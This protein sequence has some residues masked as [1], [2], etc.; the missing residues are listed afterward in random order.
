[1]KKQ[2]LKELLSTALMFIGLCITNFS[3]IQITGLLIFYLGGIFLYDSI[4]N[5]NII[6]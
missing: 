5:E 3:L 4:F 6:E 2:F 1:M